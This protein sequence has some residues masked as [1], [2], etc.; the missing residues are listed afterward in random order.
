MS[1][2]MDAPD[3]P[4][5]ASEDDKGNVLVCRKIS[6]RYGRVEVCSGI[7]LSVRAGETVAI[8][9]PNGAGK[10]SFL[11]RLSGLVQGGGDIELC[12]QNIGNDNVHVRARRGIAFV[13]ETRGNICPSLSVREN[14]ALGIRLVSTNREAALERVFKLF[15]ILRERLDTAAG[16]L[17]GGE[18]Q[19]LA[20][21]MAAARQP[22]VLLLDE[23]TQGLAPAIH[24]VLRST[25]A[26]LRSDG[27]AILVAEQNI[28]FA[29]S[30]C[31]RYVTLVDGEIVRRGSPRE[32]LDHDQIMS[33]FLD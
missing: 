25:I 2:T 29:E 28:P 8:L 31:D 32:L 6:A 21:G 30:I 7:D 33:N 3:V 18:Q 24:D 4:D 17:S 9:G 15:P 16:M 20:V 10:S 14:L 23:P 22:R 26:Q 5:I 27:L 1:I 13:P 12:G 19:M 11:G